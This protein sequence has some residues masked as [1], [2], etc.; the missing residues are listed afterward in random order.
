MYTKIFFAHSYKVFNVTPFENAEI[1]DKVKNE[2]TWFSTKS[3]NLCV[4]NNFVKYFTFSR[5]LAEIFVF[6]C[7]IVTSVLLNHKFFK[8]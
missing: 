4:L 1:F 5:F 8:T 2:Y 7:V 3:T 6:L